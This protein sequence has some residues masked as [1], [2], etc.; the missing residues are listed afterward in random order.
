VKLADARR[1]HPSRV[2]HYAAI[3]RALDENSLRGAL[4]DAITRGIPF[5]GNLP[6][7]AGALFRQ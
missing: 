3:I 2:G 7:P 1:R 6:R 4:L 5:L